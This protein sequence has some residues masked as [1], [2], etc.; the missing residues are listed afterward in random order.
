MSRMISMGIDGLITNEPALARRIMEMR[1]ELSAA[2]RLM[3]W[4]SDRLHIGNF[5]LVADESDA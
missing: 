1:N 3:L 4:L 2:D 5:K